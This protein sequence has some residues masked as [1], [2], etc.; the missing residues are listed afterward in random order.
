MSLNSLQ[1]LLAILEN[2]SSWQNVRILKLCRESW[3]NLVGAKAYEYSR[4]LYINRKILYCA[5]SSSTWAQNLSLQRYF[6]LKQVNTTLSLDLIDIRFSPAQ[7]Y[8]RNLNLEVEP[9]SLQK[10]PS[11][12]PP[13]ET[14]SSSKPLNKENVAQNWL[15]T[16]KKRSENLPLCPKCQ[17]PTPVGEIK[18]WGVCM[19]CFNS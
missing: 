7:W 1:Q 12:I 3:L 14:V 19:H 9:P 4:P 6:L 2:Q 18:R 15:E 13:I 16:L 5:T 10:Q 17:V 8:Y 11:Y